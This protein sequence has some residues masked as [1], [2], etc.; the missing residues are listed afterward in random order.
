ME[1]WLTPKNT[2]LPNMC[3]HTKFRCCR[4]NHFGAYRVPLPKNLCWAQSLGM[5]AWMTLSK[6][7]PASHVTGYHTKFCHYRSNCLCIHRDP[8]N[9]G[10]VMDPSLG[11]GMWPLE[12]CFSHLYYHAKFSHFTSNHS[13]VIME[14]CQK[15]LTP[16][17]LSFT[18]T[19]SHWNQRGSISYLWLRIGVR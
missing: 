16:H 11:M 3:Y 10:N 13:T 19:Q 9:F 15:N 4:S 7:A 6:H 2:L 12:I 14:I 5:G 18:V 8:K 17:A 1:T